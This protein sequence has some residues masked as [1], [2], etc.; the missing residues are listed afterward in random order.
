MAGNCSF[1]GDDCANNEICCSGYCYN[2]SY[3][4]PLFF[5]APP[6]ANEPTPAPA[7]TPVPAASPPSTKNR[8][9]HVRTPSPSN[10]SPA[11]MHS[12]THHAS[13]LSAPTSCN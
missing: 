8:G 9:S 5:P 4:I 13:A 2:S 6:V 10:G 11:P 3:C 12:K 7:S 1:D